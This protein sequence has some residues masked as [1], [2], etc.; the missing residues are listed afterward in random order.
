MTTTLAGE[1]LASLIRIANKP[2]HRDTNHF[3]WDSLRAE[4]NEWASKNMFITRQRETL[5]AN[6][7]ARVGTRGGVQALT[8]AADSDIPAIP[9]NGFSKPPRAVGRRPNQS[10]AAPTNV[11][12]TRFRFS[13]T[14]LRRLF[15]IT[16]E[17]PRDGGRY[18]WTAIAYQYNAWA[19]EHHYN[20]RHCDTLR[21]KV[22]GR[23]HGN[24]AVSESDDEDTDD[25][26]TT[27]E[28]AGKVVPKRTRPAVKDHA[29][30][31]AVEV[32]SDVAPAS[33][34]ERVKP[35]P[36]FA[37]ALRAR[38]EQAALQTQRLDEL[39]DHVFFLQEQMENMNKLLGQVL[40]R[41]EEVAAAQA[42]QMSEVASEGAKQVREVVAELLRV[43]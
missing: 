13:K 9:V 23:G 40:D 11:L 20:L 34:P 22:L 37:G 27:H 17:L 25:E 38:Q 5:K 18:N 4:Y 1:E 43:L 32:Q 29:E 3:L 8:P 36:G 10:V 42:K 12:H 16:K 21:T 24:P 19:A 14:E 7:L 33:G 35:T 41:Q 28:D 6:V 39:S 15:K 2:E 31:S 26:S 30:K